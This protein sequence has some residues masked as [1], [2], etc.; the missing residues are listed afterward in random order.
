MNRTL[1][2]FET[3]DL[4]AQEEMQLTK[5]K[6]QLNYVYEHSRFYK[7]KFDE[8]DINPGD[9]KTMEDFRRIPFTTKDEI[10]DHNDDFICVEN[11]EVIDIG[12]TTGTTGSPVILPVTRKDWDDVV[13]TVSRALAGLEIQ[14]EDICQITVS[15]DQ[16]FSAATPFDIALKQMGVT[17][18][19][20]GPGNARRQLEIMQ[21][22]GTTVI[23]AIPDF[24]FILAE[25]A[26]EMGLDPRKDFN[27]RMGIMVGQSLYTQ[28]MQPN[29]L[30]RRL[31]ELWGIDCY[32]NY[33][34]MEM[35]AGFIECKPHGGHHVY[36]DHLII[37]IIDPDN[38][39][40]V[41]PGQTGEL[42]ATHLAREGIPLV[43][44]R[45]GDITSIK[46]DQCSCGRTTPRIM[47][48]IGRVD[49]MLKIKGTSVYPAQIEEALLS[50]AG[51]SAYVIEAFSDQAGTDRIKVMVTGDDPHDLLTTEIEKAVKA[52]ARITPDVV[53]PITMEE[54]E[55]IWFSKDNRKPKRFWDKRN[56]APE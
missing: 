38:G 20:M 47:G 45:Q 51:V 6:K 4:Q 52:K 15:F 40:V 33:G 29:N 27:L 43:R 8:A 56:T 19:R 2:E 25:E 55:R 53:E 34:S 11:R 3:M 1:G 5:L 16:L 39:L 28:D 21:R 18:L 32:T 22:M 49:Q 13:E 54:A 44:F 37:E 10:R 35:M 24:M 26:G 42:V 48:T 12:T 7:R 30:K 14:K 41:A 46:T 23:Y 50:V 9:I 36:A 31:G 17:T